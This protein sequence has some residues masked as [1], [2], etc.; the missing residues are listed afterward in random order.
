MNVGQWLEH[1][2]TLL[3]LVA[4]TGVGF[5]FIGR[6][7]QR[8]EDHVGKFEDHKRQNER[9]HDGLHANITRLYDKIDLIH[10]DLRDW[11]ASSAKP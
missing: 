9:E 2:G 4:A 3:G 1:F 7:A 5:Y 8:I 10:K 11:R 6:L